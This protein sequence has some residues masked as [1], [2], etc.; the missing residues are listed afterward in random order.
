MSGH[1]VD[2]KNILTCRVFKALN[3]LRSG[4][5]TIRWKTLTSTKCQPRNPDVGC[6]CSYDV[7]SSRLKCLIHLTPSETS[8]DL[9]CSTRG[10]DLSLVEACHHDLYAVRR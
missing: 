3:H 2:C 6:T 8:P 5:P 4:S 10:V 7:H 1:V 9:N